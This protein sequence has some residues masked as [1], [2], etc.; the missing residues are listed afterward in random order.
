[1]IGRRPRRMRAARMLEPRRV[2]V[3]DV[4][5]RPPAPHEVV[6]EVQRAGICGTDLHIWHGDY[7]AA[8]FPLVP[9]HEFSGRVEALG[10]GVTSFRPGDRVTADPNV[11]CGRC[12]ECRR[13]AFN[14]CLDL[15]IVG[16]T[17]DG[18]FARY[19][20]VPHE[21][22]FG[23]GDM[24]YAEGAL[25]EPLACVVWSMHRLRMRLGDTVLLFGAG[26]MGCLLVQA[27]LRS[28]ASEVT[29]VDRSASRLALALALGAT[30]TCLAAELPEA[31][32]EVAPNGFDVVVEATGVPA[33]LEAAVAY[34]RPRGTI[35][36]FG[37]APE[38][39]TVSLSPYEVFRKDL[40]VIGSFAL[41]KTFG[42][43]IVLARSGAVELA[44]L[45]SHV[46]PL[47]DCEQG[48]ELAE[49]DPNRMKVQ[50][51]VGSEP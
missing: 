44:P 50:F 22:V 32:P 36:V 41:N 49:H 19:V 16:V 51:S 1:V 23:I 21:V 6:I 31:A 24:T 17:R 8:R 12:V 7:A 26:P 42:E 18:A 29:V 4:P 9:G 13:T 35:L 14:Q 45:V 47:A 39:A 3:T 5:L 38:T 27:L 43:A 10:E 34:A 40:T 20:T 2:H 15:E 28:G 48:L 37:V 25:V 11:P 33:V 46:V 30:R